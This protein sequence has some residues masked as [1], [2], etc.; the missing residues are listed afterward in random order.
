M[1][2][3]VLLAPVALVA[4]VGCVSTSKPMRNAQGEI[5]E[6]RTSGWG[7][8]GAPMALI[9]QGDCVR[10]LRKQGYYAVG[11]APGDVKIPN[12]AINYRSSI[13]FS[14]PEGWSAQPITSD[15][16][17]KAVRYFAMNQTIDSGVMVSAIKR[18]AVT[19]FKTYVEST[20]RNA[21]SL[22]AGVVST[23]VQYSQEGG[24]QVARYGVETT[25]QASRLQYGY[26]V[27]EGAAEIAI[28][29]AWTSDANYETVE[30]TLRDL[31]GRLSGI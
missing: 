24:R 11:E 14:P 3:K 20:R 19:D 9:Q 26:T 2:I 18:S 5:M 6:C 25:V 17:G 27:I 23:D 7:W 12:S 13:S 4:L 22:G 1:N 16:K 10:D 28:V 8:L 31:S 15:L 29:A 30:Q 21:M